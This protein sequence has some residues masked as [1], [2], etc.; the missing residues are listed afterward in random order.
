MYF[1]ISSFVKLSSSIKSEYPIIEVKGVF[2]S[3]EILAIIGFSGSGKSTVLKLI[4]GLIPKDS[5]S[6]STT[7]DIAMVF[8]YSALIDSLNIKDGIFKEAKV[9]WAKDSYNDN[10]YKNL[11]KYLNHKFKAC[12]AVMIDEYLGKYRLF[13]FYKE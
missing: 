2:I 4:S 9:I 6:I 7:G 13:K 1:F 10:E 12:E 3:C 11:E 8:Q 5:G